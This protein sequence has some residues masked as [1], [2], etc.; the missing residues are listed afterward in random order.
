[1]TLKVTLI[2]LSTVLTGLGA[3][4]SLLAA[5]PSRGPNRKRIMAMA[6]TA[7]V[8]VV[9]GLFTNMVKDVFTERFQRTSGRDRVQM[10]TASAFD[11]EAQRLVERAKSHFAAAEAS[12]KESQYAEASA[13]YRRSIAEIPTLPAYLNLGICLRW[14]DK[15]SEARQVLT[16]GLQAAAGRRDATDYEANLLY[17]LAVVILESHPDA[18]DLAAALDQLK[19][20]REI[21]MREASADAR[22]AEANTVLALAT[23][24]DMQQVFDPTLFDTA[25]QLFAAQGDRLGQAKVASNLAAHF[26]ESDPQK[27]LQLCGKAIGLFN[28]VDIESASYGASAAKSLCGIALLE[29]GQADQALVVTQEALTLAERA[30]FNRLGKSPEA[31]AHAAKARDLL[32]GDAD[33]ARLAAAGETVPPVEAPGASQ[34]A[35]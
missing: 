27:A 8:C 23:A 22:L 16:T 35:R 5:V 14:T 21:F 12:F 19:R 9:L 13:E 29:L 26:V 32:P 11:A 30:K 34:S 1:M 17:N 33:V 25:A 6:S 3:V 20:A 7:I 10:A 2:V 24:Y 28:Q 31:R 15:R 4:Y 18:N